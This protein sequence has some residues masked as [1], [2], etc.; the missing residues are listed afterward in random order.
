MWE[1][2]SLSFTFLIGQPLIYCL[3]HHP[4]I[5]IL[6]W[7]LY[8]CHSHWAYKIQTCI[9]KCSI[10]LLSLRLPI[11][12]D[13]SIVAFDIWQPWCWPT[14]EAD[15]AQSICFDIVRGRRCQGWGY[16]KKCST[17]LGKNLY[18]YLRKLWRLLHLVGWFFL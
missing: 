18:V 7:W 4:L 5:Y 12:A 1:L 15:F 9:F 11:P 8:A 2:F 14:E 3:V 6:F 10:L 17:I 13:Q 16:F